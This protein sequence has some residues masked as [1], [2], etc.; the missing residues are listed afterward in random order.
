MYD[1]LYKRKE[2]YVK[3]KKF[4]VGDRVR[5]SKKKKIF[6]KGFTPNWREELFIIKEVKPTIPVTY[7]IVDLNGENIKGTFYQQELQKTKETV[8][9]IEKVLK[10]RTKSD[11]SKEVLIKWKRYSNDFNS[12]IPQGNIQ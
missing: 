4:K 8:Y 11:G 7:S 9:R 10:K 5:I 3:P 12:W 6:E 1:A 2:I